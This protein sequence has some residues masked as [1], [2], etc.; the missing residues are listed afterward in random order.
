[1]CKYFIK[2]KHLKEKLPFSPSEVDNYFL[3]NEEN[4]NFFIKNEELLFN[5]YPDKNDAPKIN[6]KTIS[7][8]EYWREVRERFAD[9]QKG[10]DGLFYGEFFDSYKKI[11]SILKEASKVS[12]KARDSAILEKRFFTYPPEPLRHI[13]MGTDISA[14]RIRQRQNNAWKKLSAGIYEYERYEVYRRELKKTLIKI[15]PEGISFVLNRIAIRN[16]YIGE[17]LSMIVWK[18]HISL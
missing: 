7:A 8:E 11:L 17:W 10:G 18:K 14:E 15:P 12:L 2:Y 16:K 1:M 9:F 5:K 3:L 13:A 4:Y 6:K